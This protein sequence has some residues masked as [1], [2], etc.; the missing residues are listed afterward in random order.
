MR[1]SFFLVKLNPQKLAYLKFI[2][3]G[4]DHL[5]ILSVLDSKKGLAKIYFFEKEKSLIK[6]ILEDLKDFLSLEL[7]DIF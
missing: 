3:E 4:Y 2:L 7:I 1:S 6:E 5:A